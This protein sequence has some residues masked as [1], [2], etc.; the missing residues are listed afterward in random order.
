[1]INDCLSNDPSRLQGV[2]KIRSAHDGPEEDQSC[3]KRCAAWT[4]A[5]KMSDH[6]GGDAP[7]D[8]NV[9]KEDQVEVEEEPCMKVNQEKECIACT[10]EMNDRTTSQ[11]AVIQPLLTGIYI[12][13]F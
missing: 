4:R 11:N 3:R 5:K 2:L 6:D 7:D 1:L 8:V 10:E 9:E 13:F 12:T